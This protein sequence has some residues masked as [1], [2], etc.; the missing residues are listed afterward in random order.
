MAED[1]LHPEDAGPAQPQGP[2]RRAFLTGAT[3]AVGAL[4]MVGVAVPFVRSWSPSAKARALGGDVEV[5]ITELPATGLWVREWRG[6]PVFIYRYGEG[7]DGLLQDPERRLADPDS[8]SSSQPEFA[9]NPR[10]SLRRDVA[11]LVGLCTHLG[12]APKYVPDASPQAFDSN[13]KG[14]FFCPCHGSKFDLSGRVYA[15][16]P[17]PTNMVVP[18]YH[19]VDDNTLIIGSESPA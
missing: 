16:V 1:A 18:P 3:A 10:R 11:V 9:R 12:C 7:A 8:E 14:G 6:Q 17:A 15:G 13:W 4:G 2:S 19:F 5:D